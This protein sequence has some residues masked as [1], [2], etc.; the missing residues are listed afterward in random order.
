MIVPE[1]WRRGSTPINTF[2]VNIDLTNS[3]VFV[4]Y[5][6]GG[7]VIV[8]KTGSDL[9]ITDKTISTRL[10]Q[11]DTL[12]FDDSMLVEMQIR[13]VKPNGVA[14]GSNVIT[15]SVGKILKDGVIEYVQN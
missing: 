11:E 14:D 5:S 1:G 10:S 13:Y 2:K 3:T 7:D 8:E 6:Q 9:I 4:T 15:A 12:K